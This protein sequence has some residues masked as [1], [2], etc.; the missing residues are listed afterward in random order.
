V[1]TDMETERGDGRASEA[2]HYRGER[3]G[4]FERKLSGIVIEF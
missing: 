2:C 3:A 4:V 1:L